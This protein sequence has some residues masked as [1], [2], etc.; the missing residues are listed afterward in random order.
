MEVGV[1]TVVNVVFVF[2]SGFAILPANPIGAVV[3]GGF[4][5]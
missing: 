5:S 4:G 3:S 1:A 2:V